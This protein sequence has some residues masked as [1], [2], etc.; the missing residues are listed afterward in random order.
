MSIPD[1]NVIDSPT[2]NVLLVLK[3]WFKPRRGGWISYL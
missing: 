1:G 2:I 3:W